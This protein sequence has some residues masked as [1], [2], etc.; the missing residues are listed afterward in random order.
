[1]YNNL[2]IHWASSIPAF[3]ALACTPAPFI[4]HRYGK[5]IRLKCRYAAQAYEYGQIQRNAQKPTVVAEG[6]GESNSKIL[7]AA[8]P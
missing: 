2:G 7:E 8:S 4:F 5:E 6:K 1:M 3:L